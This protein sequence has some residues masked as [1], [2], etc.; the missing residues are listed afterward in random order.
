MK[1]TPL[2]TLRVLWIISTASRDSV[3]EVWRTGSVKSRV[4]L[5]EPQRAS[6]SAVVLLSEVQLTATHTAVR[7][8]CF[9]VNVSSS[10]QREELW[11]ACS[12]SAD[13]HVWRVKD[14][15][16]ASQRVVLPDCSGCFCMIPVKNQVSALLPAR[17]AEGAP[18]SD[19][20]PV[21]PG[22]GGSS[23]TQLGQR[24]ALHRGPGALRSSEGA[25]GS[26]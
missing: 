26:R 9:C 14:T 5:P 25:S 23:R 12:D 4:H 7:L 10:H 13:L 17:P 11:G 21:L 19:P 15:A 20:S 18:P 8:S 24:E 2:E 3:M 1:S 16:R 6:F 22:V